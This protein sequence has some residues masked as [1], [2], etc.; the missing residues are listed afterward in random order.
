MK[1]IAVYGSAIVCIL[2]VGFA[3]VEGLK[4]GQVQGGAIFL[5]CV[6]LMYLF[7]SLVWGTPEGKSEADKDER[8][9][10]ITLVSSKIS[11]FV[12][13]GVMLIVLIATEGVAE[14]NDVKNIPLLIVMCA[15]LF[16]FPA[17]QLIVAKRYQ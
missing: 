17:T 15:A 12:L 6:A 4:T 14:L 5:G 2:S 8:E 3:V 7:N 13:L 10:H 11:Y 9:K 1:K 16:I